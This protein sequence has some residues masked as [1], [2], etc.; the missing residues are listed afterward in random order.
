LKL[1]SEMAWTQLNPLL[2]SMTIAEP[3]AR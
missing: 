3:S 1:G 2:S